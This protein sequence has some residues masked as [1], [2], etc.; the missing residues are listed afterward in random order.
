M[1]M[2]YFTLVIKVMKGLK[3]ILSRLGVLHTGFTFPKS[4]QTNSLYKA[5]NT[6]L[7]GKIFRNKANK[8]C[9][10]VVN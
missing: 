9:F 6:A 4:L 7:A 3:D 5:L 8:Q 1:K 2:K 10:P